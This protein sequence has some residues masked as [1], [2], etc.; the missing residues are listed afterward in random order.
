MSSDLMRDGLHLALCQRHRRLLAWLRTHLAPT[1][2]APPR[3]DGP[4]SGR[5]RAHYHVTRQLGPIR[6][7]RPFFFLIRTEK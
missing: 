6:I 7:T 3:K 5:H 4:G 1:G 2:S